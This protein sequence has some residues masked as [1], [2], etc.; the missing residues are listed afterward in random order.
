MPH[1]GIDLNQH[2]S[3]ASE[4]CGTALHLLSSKGPNNAAYQY[5]MLFSPWCFLHALGA[6][7][8]IAPML[9]AGSTAQGSN[10]SVGDLTSVE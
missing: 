3:F 5:V 9:G 6:L 2:Q 8:C 7:Q 1:S 10:H 4:A